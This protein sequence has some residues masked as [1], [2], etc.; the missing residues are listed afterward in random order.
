VTAACSKLQSEELVQFAP[1]NKHYY[2]DKTKEYEMGGHVAS[3]GS[4]DRCTKLLLVSVK[5]RGYL[6]AADGRTDGRTDGVERINGAQ[7][8]DGG[9]R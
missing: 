4:G 7:D 1:F 9:G 3:M 2:N 5:E 8:T 6:G